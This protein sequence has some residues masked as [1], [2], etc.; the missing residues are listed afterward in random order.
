MHKSFFAA[1]LFFLLISSAFCA[2][3]KS[4][5]FST[6]SENVRIVLESDAPVNYSS[7]IDGAD[8]LISMQDSKISKEASAIKLLDGLVS[9][10][11]FEQHT[12]K[13]SLFIETGYAV[14]PKVFSLRDP[15]RI[16]VDLPRKEKTAA[17]AAD[18]KAAVTLKLPEACFVSSETTEKMP[19]ALWCGNI[20]KVS[21]GLYYMRIDASAQKPFTAHV[22]LCDRSYV[23]VMPVMMVR[24]V[25][26]KNNI[27]VISAVLDFFGFIEE[28]KKQT[29]HFEKKRVSSFVKMTNA[30]AGVNGSFFYKDG[31]P[32]GA[33]MIGGQIISSPLYN[34]TALILYENGRTAIDAL[35]MQGYLKL[36]NGQ[37]LGFSGVNQ[38]LKA[39][40]IIV[41]TPDYRR[42]DASESSTNITVID[43]KV[44]G[45]S[46]GDIQIPNN[47]Y[48]ISAIGTAGEALKD[49]FSQNK[50]AKWF[51]MASP[52]LDG[53]KHVL[54]GGPRLLYN[55]QPYI[56]SKEERFR[57][58]V[59]IG[60]AART[61]AGITKDGRLIFAVV[62]GNG[63][64]TGATLEELS[65]FMKDLGAYDAM[66]LDGGGSSSMVVSGERMLQGGERAVSN[67]IIIKK[68]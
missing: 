12:D 17:L 58:D 22:L 66:N 21:R 44:A 39:N 3:I 35:K 2:E 64:K 59:T 45:I 51:F 5:R 33:L 61:A 4:I 15:F 16:V 46:F 43:D 63:K 68:P 30:L 34:R 9:N 48:V 47:G 40:Q 1:L 56:S 29:E 54:A 11:S 52:A 25:K 41:Y 31:T 60:K 27:P 8:I 42:T 7:V 32:V 18:I 57:N 10:I 20:S 67:A 62:E 37:T 26:A 23:E 49:I 65:A 6:S 24:E 19:S 28:E 36:E 38:P 13:L 50:S 53:V 55:G 14:E